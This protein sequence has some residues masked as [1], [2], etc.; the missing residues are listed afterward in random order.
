[1]NQQINEIVVSDLDDEVREGGSLQ[2]AW[3]YW[4]IEMPNEGG[5]SASV[6]PRQAANHFFVFLQALI[7][8]GKLWGQNGE[9]LGKIQLRKIEAGVEG[10]IFKETS[11]DGCVSACLLPLEPSLC[12]ICP[13]W[14][15]LTRKAAQSHKRASWILVEN[16]EI[17]LG[18]WFLG[19]L[20]VPA[21]S[22]QRG[23]N[24][25][26]VTGSSSSRKKRL[27]VSVTSSTKC[28]PGRSF[29]DRASRRNSARSRR[30]RARA[31]PFRYTPSSLSPGNSQWSLFT[32][33]QRWITTH[34]EAPLWL[35]PWYVIAEGGRSKKEEIW[36][37]MV[38]ILSSLLQSSF[39]TAVTHSIPTTLYVALLLF[40][41]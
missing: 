20:V 24:R 21:A 33:A 38:F 11:Q 14:E 30:L 5:Q 8:L 40:F 23:S 15:M 6:D 25:A 27:S 16:R 35:P 31:P 28:S 4:P 19:I 22:L 3:S 17:P 13:G 36:A 32:I 26:E 29:T 41:K 12:M 39:L 7:L 9:G 34:P 1:M 2:R 18:P 10:G 37:T